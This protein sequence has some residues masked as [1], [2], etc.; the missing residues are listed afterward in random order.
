MPTSRLRTAVGGLSRAALVSTGIAGSML[1]W[2][3]FQASSGEA[4]PSG[5]RFA[6]GVIGIAV[7]I[8]LIWCVACW[9]RAEDRRRGLN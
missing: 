2:A 4:L 5:V 6:A 8:T 9:A 3:L 1:T 7:A